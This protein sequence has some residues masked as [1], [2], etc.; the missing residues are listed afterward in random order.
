MATKR[1]RFKF[2]EKKQSISGII[3]LIFG[4]IFLVLF[5]MIIGKSA[6]SSGNLSMYYGSAGILLMILAVVDFIVAV[7]STREED[8][9]QFFPKLATLISFV[10]MCCW[11]GT[12]VQGFINM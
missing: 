5:S 10:N 11:I 3:A 7:K 12:Y 2:T 1:N 6:D 8:S 4:V 9:F